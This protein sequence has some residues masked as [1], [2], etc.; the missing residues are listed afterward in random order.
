MNVLGKIQKSTK[1]FRSNRK[2]IM[3]IDKYDN[4]KV[5]STSYQITFI[6]NVRFMTTSS[7]NFVDNLTE[8]IQKILCKV[9]DCFLEHESVKDNLQIKNSHLAIKVIQTKLMK[10]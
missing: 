10:N 9:D 7:S 1:F 5:A 8:R 4:K 6:Y 2:E 3:K